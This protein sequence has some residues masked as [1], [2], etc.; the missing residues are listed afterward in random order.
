MTRLKYIFLSI[1]FSLCFLNISAQ[2]N[3]A[4]IEE[5]LVINEVSDPLVLNSY[6]LAPQ[7][8]YTE[9]D[10]G[11]GWGT[12]GSFDSIGNGQWETSMTGGSE[13]S[14]ISWTV[15]YYVQNS[16]SI[17]PLVRYTK[18]TLKT[19]NSL[20]LADR[21]YAISNTGNISVDVLSNDQSSLNSLGV[22]SVIRN[23]DLIA[24]QSGNSLELSPLSSDHKM[25]AQYIAEDSIGTVDVGTVVLAPN[26]VPDQ[27]LSQTH[28]TTNKSS[29][30]FT[31][32][33]L[34]YSLN[35]GPEHGAL[36]SI[37]SYAY[38]YNP[39]DNY[40]GQDSLKF[41]HTNGTSYTVNFTI[42]EQDIVNSFLTDDE[43]YV[44]QEG[45]VLFNVTN[46]DLESNLNI[47]S[48]SADEYEELEYLGN[49]DFRYTAPNNFSGIVNFEYSCLFLSE[50]K[51]ANIQIVVSDQAPSI[52]PYDFQTPTN[53][54]H[55]LNFDTPVSGETFIIKEAPN[56]GTLQILGNGDVISGTCYD[57]SGED[58]IVYIPNVDYVG[59]DN[60]EIQYQV[61]ANNNAYTLMSDIEVLAS[62]ADCNCVEDCV[63]KG[64]TNNDGTVNL[65]DLFS[66]GKYFGTTTEPRTDNT[67]EWVGHTN[68]SNQ[69]NKFADIN[70]D[71]IV[72]E[73]DLDDFFDYYELSHNYFQSTSLISSE[74]DIEFVP[75]VTEIDSGELLRIDVVLGS[76]DFPAINVD[77]ISFALNIAPTLADSSSMDV[78]YK[79]NSWFCHNDPT[80]HLTHVP[81][82]G[83]IE[84]GVANTANSSESGIGIIAT[85]EFIVEEDMDGFRL[86]ENEQ[87]VMSIEFDDIFVAGKD[88][89]TYKLADQTVE[90]P[91]KQNSEETTEPSYNVNDLLVYPNPSSDIINLY[92]N[93]Q[94]HIQEINVFTTSG[95]L[96]TNIK[97]VNSD[98]YQLN[99][100]NHPIGVYF[101]QVIS[102]NY[103]YTQ[104]VELIK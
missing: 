87:P 28:F 99:L 51:T 50:V 69:A 27:N 32:P 73:D 86:G 80:V 34:G 54:P 4:L 74:Y 19:V 82:D 60:F 79:S 11:V 2:S 26:L 7:I 92:L 47:L 93:G 89:K 20:V 18:I 46:N 6:F 103:S 56:H 17:I 49:G 58:K 101:V 84:T 8:V 35:D 5:V 10:N 41:T 102:E 68:A 77:G 33:A 61:N 66:F 57:I 40:S 70:G 75:Q 90:I 42:F 78:I 37:N 36:N 12:L 24:T 45:V 13:V 59:S 9:V 22:N 48:S 30:E 31:L 76:E 63:W 16:P 71:G 21:D 39:D 95:H 104:K 23:Q 97:H 14:E 52:Y 15:K 55:V 3:P 29:L 81:Y 65:L 53:T 88:G 44:A 100:E 91:W 67:T 62:E 85:L 94:D 72:A 64:D 83:R 1:V 25:Y 38:I 43:V 96:M 98:A